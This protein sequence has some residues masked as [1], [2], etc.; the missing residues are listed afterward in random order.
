MYDFADYVNG[1]GEIKLIC[2]ASFAENELGLL[3]YENAYGFTLNQ[4]QLIILNHGNAA[5]MLKA[6]YSSTDGVNASL[7]YGT[8]GSL[9]NLNMSAVDDPIGVPPV[10]LPAPVVR[11][12]IIETYPEIEG[13]FTEVFDTLTKETLQTLNAKIAFAGEDPKEVAEYYLKNKG[14]IE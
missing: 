8:D 9:D 11:G 10:Y 13:L 5:E 4:D 1:G 2:A 6:L 14:F 12:E 3:G 7:V